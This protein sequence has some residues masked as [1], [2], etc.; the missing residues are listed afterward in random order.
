MKASLD[1]PQWMRGLSPSGLQLLSNVLGW[2]WIWH[3]V[4]LDNRDNRAQWQCTVQFC[5]Y[6]GLCFILDTGNQ[7]NCILELRNK[8]HLNSMCLICMRLGLVHNTCNTHRGA[9]HKGQQNAQPSVENM[10]CVSCKGSRNIA[11]EEAESLSEL[12]A[13]DD[14]KWKQPCSWACALTLVVTSY[15][16]SV[17]V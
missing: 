5:D 7:K 13:V 2:Q 16:T 3:T 6:L 14:N 8:A 1:F 9:E 17:Q 11:E 15:T 10:F 12:V 4:S